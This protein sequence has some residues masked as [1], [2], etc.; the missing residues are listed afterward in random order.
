MPHSIQHL[1]LLHP[2]TPPCT[3]PSQQQIYSPSLFFFFLNP[4]LSSGSVVAVSAAVIYVGQ[5]ARSSCTVLYC[6]VL[7]CIVLYCIVFIAL[8]FIVLAT[9][10]TNLQYVKKF[11]QNARCRIGQR[12]DQWQLSC[13]MQEY[14][15]TDRHNG[16]RSLFRDRFEKAPAGT[17]VNQILMVPGDL[18]GIRMRQSRALPLR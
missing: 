7:H 11:N 17:E 5:C 4:Y 3:S 6:I 14:R 15:R 13:S 16:A 8:Y 18:A 1:S 2:H 9:F 10:S 12:S